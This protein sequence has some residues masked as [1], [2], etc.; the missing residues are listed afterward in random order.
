ML[1][2]EWIRINIWK[3]NQK[4]QANE[5]KEIKTNVL[6]SPALQWRA[7]TSSPSAICKNFSRIANGGFDPSKK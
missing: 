3:W 1:N 4:K 5:Y 2:L 6:P 7:I